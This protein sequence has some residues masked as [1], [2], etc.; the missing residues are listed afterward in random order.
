MPEPKLNPE[1]ARQG[2]KGTPVLKILIIGLALCAVIF[3]GLGIY[4]SV[5]PDADMAI[6]GES[7]TTAPAADTAEPTGT[8]VTP[9]EDAPAQ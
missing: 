8:T 9:A 7:T 4:G 5:L 2:E 6:E 1:D 3:I